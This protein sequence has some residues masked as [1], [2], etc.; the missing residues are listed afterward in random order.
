[1]KQFSRLS[2]SLVATDLLGVEYQRRNRRTRSSSSLP[3]LVDN[4]QGKIVYEIVV[5]NVSDSSEE[6]YSAWGER[7]SP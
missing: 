5:S 6:I 4:F 3:A 2:R 1:M 7:F